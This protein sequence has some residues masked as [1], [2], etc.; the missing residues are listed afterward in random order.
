MVRSI[1]SADNS[2]IVTQVTR[3]MSLV[4][5][6]GVNANVDIDL[7]EES[8][9]DFLIGKLKIIVIAKPPG[10]R[11]I[12]KR[13]LLD[14][15]GTGFNAYHDDFLGRCGIA[16]QMLQIEF[17]GLITQVKFDQWMFQMLK[18]HER[19]KLMSVLYDKYSGYNR[20][21]GSMNLADIWPQ[22]DRPDNQ[23]SEPKT[24]YAYDNDFLVYAKKYA[25]N[26]F[27]N[28]MHRLG[29]GD[30]FNG[31]HKARRN[32]LMPIDSCF[33]HSLDGGHLE[34]MTQYRA[35]KYPI[36]TNV[37]IGD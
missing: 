37:K 32:D 1:Y 31:Y 21:Y 12:S 19:A 4:F 7:Y 13:A 22:F 23:W 6:F 35:K 24:N 34:R 9:E 36:Y 28:F 5:P 2:K 29:F 14:I 18:S 8:A 10:V 3:I 16:Q 26:Q 27:R 25:D 33:T 30:Y 11:V 17:P 20:V 15:K